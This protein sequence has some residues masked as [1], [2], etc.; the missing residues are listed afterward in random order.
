MV[1]KLNHL[2]SKI[3]AGIDLLAINTNSEL[4]AQISEVGFYDD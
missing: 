2:F 1:F 4:S 3:L